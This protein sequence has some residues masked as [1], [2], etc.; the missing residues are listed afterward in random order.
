LELWVE[1]DDRAIPHRLVITY[2]GLPGT[3]N[4]IAEFSDWNFQNRPSDAD[5]VFRP[6]AGATKVDVPPP[7][8]A[9]GIDE[10]SNYYRRWIS[11]SNG[12]SGHR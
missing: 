10:A 5:F 11:L 9:G 1:N 4:F 7:R 8:T 6:P 2:R 3:P 12:D